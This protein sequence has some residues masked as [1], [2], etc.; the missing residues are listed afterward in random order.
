MCQIVEE[1]KDIEKKR[2]ECA[3][4]R[5]SWCCSQE[6]KERDWM[7]MCKKHRYKND[8]EIRFIELLSETV[9]EQVVRKNPRGFKVAH[10]IFEFFRK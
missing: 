8:P 2:N 5:K 3:D 1:K 7:G 10:A 6:I 9:M 4:C